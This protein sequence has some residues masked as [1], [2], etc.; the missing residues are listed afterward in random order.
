MKTSNS[1]GKINKL[2]GRKI[3]IEDITRPTG[4]TI[5]GSEIITITGR[6]KRKILI[7]KN[8]TMGS[9]RITATTTT[10]TEAA[11]EIRI[12]MIT[13]RNIRRRQIRVERNKRGRR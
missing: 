10:R 7:T 11:I 3:E 2:A 9:K 4:T 13:I 8:D 1:K 6:I 12:V 5:M